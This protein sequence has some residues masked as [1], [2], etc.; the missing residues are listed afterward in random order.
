MAIKTKYAIFLNPYINFHTL[1]F[2]Q[3]VCLGMYNS[4]DMAQKRLKIFTKKY[5]TTEDKYTI[6]PIEYEER[7]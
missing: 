4:L 7:N 5:N 6:L 3:G 1:N 2:Y